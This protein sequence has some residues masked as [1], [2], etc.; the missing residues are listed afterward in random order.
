VLLLSKGRFHTRDGDKKSH[1][2]NLGGDSERQLD[3]GVCAATGTDEDE[4]DVAG[5]GKSLHRL[6]KEDRP[7]PRQGSS[8]RSDR[9]STTE[10][11]AVS[12]SFFLQAKFSDCNDNPPDRIAFSIGEVSRKVT[13]FLQ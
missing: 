4:S 7:P 9:A 2:A 13:I 6:T 1:G 5:F 10:V 8:W 12:R 11:F 3:M